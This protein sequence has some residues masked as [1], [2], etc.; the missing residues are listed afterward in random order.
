[1]LRPTS[2][3]LLLL[4]PAAACQTPDASTA[5][6]VHSFGGPTMG[7]SYEIKYVGVTPEAE[8]RA[9]VAAV[10]AQF[11]ATF[12]Q[13][14]DD[15]EISACN[16]HRSRRAQ[17]VS[18]LLR[19]ALALAL[20]LAAAT[21]GAFDPTVKPLSDVFRRSKATGVLDDAA[22]DAARA[23]VGYR[24]LHLRGNVIEK[25]D[26]AI[27]L[28]LDAL[29]AGLCCD[30][31][32]AALQRAGV[33][34]FL[35][36]ITGEFL[37]RGEK[38]PGVPWTVG[39]ADPDRRGLAG[40]APLAVLPLRD[41]ALCTSGDYENFVVSGG[42]SWHHIFDP[43][44]GRNPQNR[45]VSVAVLARTAAL[46]DGLGTGLMVLG[47]ERAASVFAAVAPAEERLAALFVL[48][49]DDGELE[50]VRI[51]WPQ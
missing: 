9:I 12:S 41:A 4:L 42:K 8:V 5:H 40:V 32:A 18:P 27:E 26:P 37:A 49:T 46:S 13:W 25:D 11:D 31:L 34:D 45:V 30:E 47:P 24:R 1:M 50:Q 3:C 21:D 7:S 33:R 20:Q 39:V 16:R 14:R 22:L 43:R 51:G 19:R 48:R 44:T 38:A 23:H 35:L 6:V 28:D 36:D 15:S 17:P 29:V 2:L 10:L